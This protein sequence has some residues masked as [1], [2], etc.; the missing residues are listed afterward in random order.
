MPVLEQ[1]S[2]NDV[3]SSQFFSEASSHE[4]DRFLEFVSRFLDETGDCLGQDRVAR[5]IPAMIALMRAHL[6]GRI[7]TPSSLIAASGLPRGTG[8]R[9]VKEMVASGMIEMRPRTRT[10]KTFSL[11]PSEALIRHWLDYMQRTKSLLGTAFGLDRETDYFFGA[12]YLSSAAI[13][14]L[15]AMREKLALPG[16]GALRLLLHAD[17]T[18]MAMQKLKRQLEL[19]CGADIEVRALS[20]DRL[21][22]EILANADRP[23]S[24]YDI[25][26][27]DLCWME[28]MIRR[29]AIRQ[30]V[31]LDSGAFPEFPDFHPEA[32]SSARRGNLLY[33]IPVQTTPELLIYRRDLLEASGIEPPH[34]LV[35]LLAAARAL[36][37]PAREISGI[38]WN[39]ARGTPIGTTFMMLMADFGQP[40]LNLPRVGQGFSDRELVR[41]NLRPMLD[42]P[43]ALAAARFLVELLAVSPPNVLQMSWFERAR[44]YADGH[45]AMAYCYTQ[46]LP[47]IE[48]HPDSAGRGRTGYLPHPPSV[49]RPAIAPL[50]GWNLCLPA[51]LPEDRFDAV[52]QAVE[53]LTSAAATKLYIENGSLVSSRFSVCNDPSVAHGRPIIAIVD[54]MARTG[55]LQAWPRP[56]VPQ[57]HSLVRVLGEEIHVMLQRGT[58]P[59]DALRTAQ[60]RCEKLM[61]E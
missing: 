29:G 18:F 27:C 16:T 39:G 13:P 1:F 57:L 21:H 47:L 46:I 28:E 36:H 3:L 60:K 14:P 26:T 49:G 12:S 37:D 38:C 61:A 52:I 19:H 24:S 41:R 40:V 17:S 31:N 54:R 56:A 51:N 11:H 6:R 44:C 50:G 43:E 22:D 25:V 7:E 8:H 58:R 53:T 34:D 20:I 32:I 4:L 35:E 45:A 5:E 48:N 59:E 9:M 15:P 55:Q 23:R 2:G 33:G 10:G 30:V 42:S